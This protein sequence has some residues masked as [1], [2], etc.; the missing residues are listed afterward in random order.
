MVEKKREEKREMDHEMSVEGHHDALKEHHDRLIRMEK[1]LGI[2]HK[3]DGFKSQDQGGDEGDSKKEPH[4][5]R[6]RH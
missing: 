4:Y 5:G 2:E 1:H 6:K 3:A